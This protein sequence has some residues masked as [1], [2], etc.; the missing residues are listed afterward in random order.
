M[1]LT[2]DV[3]SA[4]RTATLREVHAF[5]AGDTYSPL[6]VV[7]PIG[8]E[9]DINTLTLKLRKEPNGAV[10]AETN[11]DSVPDHASMV[12]ATMVLNSTALQGWFQETKEA[13]LA[14]ETTAFMEIFDNAKTHVAMTVPIILRRLDST[15]SS[16][17]DGAPGKS[18]YQI[19]VEHGETRSEEEWLASLKGAPGSDGQP[20]ADGTAGKS[21]YQIAVEAGFT[22]TEAEWLASLKGAKGDP[23]AAGTNG[24]GIAS[25]TPYNGGTTITLTDGRSFNIVNGRD[26]IDG[27]T[28]TVRDVEGGKQFTFTDRTIPDFIVKNGKDGVSVT[29]VTPVKSDDGS[30]VIGYSIS[31]SDN[32]DPIFI[33]HGADGKSIS[34]KSITDNA[35]GEHVISFDG[36]DKTLT[37]RDGKDGKDGEDGKDGKD[38]QDGKDGKSL[39]ID[40]IVD[41]ND[42][43][44]TM[45]FVGVEDTVTFRNG[46]SVAVEDIVEDQNNPGTHIVK[47]TGTDKTLTVRDGASISISNVS[48]SNGVTTISFTGTDKVVQIADGASISM[49]TVDNGDGTVDLNF[50]NGEVVRLSKGA[51]GDKGEPG[52]TGQ[53]ARVFSTYQALSDY[54]ADRGDNELG[55]TVG[56]YLLVQGTG[57]VYQYNTPGRRPTSPIFN[58][59]GPQGQAGSPGA[60]GS[61]GASLLDLWREATSN[62][63]AS[64]VDLMNELRGADG[65]AAIVK[66]ISYDSDNNLVLKVQTV[67]GEEDAVIAGLKIVETG[68]T[69]DQDTLVRFYNGTSYRD[70]VI[71]RGPQGPEGAPFSIYRVLQNES[72]LTTAESLR[73]PDGKMV[74]ISTEDPSE[75]ANGRVYLRDS[76]LSN[77][78]KFI[79]DLTDTALTGPSAYQIW[80]DSDPQNADKSEE[81]F[82]QSLV[83]RTPS[84]NPAESTVSTQAGGTSTYVFDDPKKSRIVVKNGES[85]VVTKA[86]TERADGSGVDFEFKCGNETY[87]IFVRHGD[88]PSVSVTET[89][90][91]CKVTAVSA[92]GT[93]T[94]SELHYP[95]V[96][97]SRNEL[98]GKLKLS[99]QN[100]KGEPTEVDLEVPSA[101]DITVNEDGSVTYKLIDASHPEGQVITLHKGVDGV[102]P[103]VVKGTSTSTY[104]T[105]YIFD[106]EHPDGQE[107]KINHGTSVNITGVDDYDDHLEV[108]ITDAT[109]TAQD[110][111]KLSIRHGADG[112]DGIDGVDGAGVWVGPLPPSDPDKFPLWIDTSTKV[113]DLGENSEGGDIVLNEVHKTITNVRTGEKL[114]IP[115]VDMQEGRIVDGDNVIPVV[116]PSTIVDGLVRSSGE[117]TDLFSSSYSFIFT[118][119]SLSIMHPCHIKTISLKSSAYVGYTV[120]VLQA[121]DSESSPWSTVSTSLAAKQMT[122]GELTTWDM[123]SC[124]IRPGVQ[125]RLIWPSNDMYQTAIEQEA[126]I[127]VRSIGLRVSPNVSS[128]MYIVAG[129][130]MSNQ[131]AWVP[132]FSMTFTDRVVLYQEVVDMFSLGDEPYD[133]ESAEGI[134]KA[135]SDLV[136]LFGGKLH[137]PV[138]EAADNE[139]E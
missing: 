110:P 130:S 11:F 10:V 21:A 112:R 121:R 95:T 8:V 39:E 90:D 89:A 136:S 30:S 118:A 28:F 83:G 139:L 87:S 59:K 48:K 86:P 49:T 103:T 14:V 76:S 122:P 1:K 63:G 100:F 82:L 62:P 105:F 4:S 55:F 43:T 119:Q 115:Y 37:I 29:S 127:P 126:E 44:I 23:G 74:I 101:S 131:L 102:S 17:A 67:N 6:T 111:L 57:D 61:D 132:T 42:G 96:Q 58:I 104:T 19:A 54:F 18:A 133:L 34:I 98:T 7:F 79:V 46:T 78:W 114:H 128:G 108:F 33:K 77:G 69:K 16:G 32:R 134:K 45:S 35:D 70:V 97:V 38:G 113:L 116:I 71:K 36:T 109:H 22:G 64:L 92:D 68:T 117:D 125:Y 12:R 60:K 138:N 15:V 80:K 123:A 47:F 56:S 51:K 88:T 93:E 27:H 94:S 24:V 41:N 2:I 50:S 135:V 52:L 129:S 137:N 91:G 66:R 31:F 40:K 85:V 3:N 65:T 20:G 120:L 107:I 106:K 73:I 124:L 99:T 72:Q 81:E 26:G 9:F 75:E 53:Y 25:I 13:G 5:A 84:I